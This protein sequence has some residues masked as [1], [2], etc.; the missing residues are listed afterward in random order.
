MYLNQ[1]LTNSD[2]PRENLLRPSNFPPEVWEPQQRNGEWGYLIAEP[3]QPYLSWVGI[4]QTG[5]P[6][7]EEKIAWEWARA[8]AQRLGLTLRT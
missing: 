6:Q 7:E 4:N 5:N 1:N 8:D 3:G 2:I